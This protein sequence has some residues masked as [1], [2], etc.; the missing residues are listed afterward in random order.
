MVKTHKNLLLKNQESFMAEYWY[1]ASG[2]QDLRSNDD[3]TYFTRFHMDPSVEGVLTVC[4]NG[5]ALSN[6]MVAMPIYGKNT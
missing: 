4:S 6:K 2:T 3:M 5:S 1:I